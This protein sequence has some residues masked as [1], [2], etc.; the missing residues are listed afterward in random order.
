[1]CSAGFVY[2]IYAVYPHGVSVPSSITVMYSSETKLKAS[3]PLQCEKWRSHGT[4]TCINIVVPQEIHYMIVAQYYIDLRSYHLLFGSN[5]KHRIEKP[6]PSSERLALVEV[7]EC[8]STE[9]P[10]RPVKAEHKLLGPWG[11]EFPL[12]SIFE[13]QPSPSPA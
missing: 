10:G 5:T 2:H 1:M 9:R 13:Y 7:V 12:P 3:E 8:D 11:V 6:N 4:P